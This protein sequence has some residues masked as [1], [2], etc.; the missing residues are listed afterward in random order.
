MF[1]ILVRFAHV[2]GDFVAKV[3]LRLWFA[4]PRIVAQA[5]VV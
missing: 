4:S 1:T 3:A 5:Y 2:N